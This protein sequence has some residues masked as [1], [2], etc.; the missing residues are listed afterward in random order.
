MSDQS[1]NSPLPPSSDK[2]ER[3]AKGGRK[4]KVMPISLR[5]LMADPASMERTLDNFFNM[6]SK[7]GN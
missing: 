6:K 5:K 2:Q 4:L 1:Q 3:R 7:G